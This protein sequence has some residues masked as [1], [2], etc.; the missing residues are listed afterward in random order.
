MVSIN[1]EVQSFRLRET[2]EIN[3]SYL[4][5][6]SMSDLLLW[7]WTA[8][9]SL[10]QV[11]TSSS[12][13]FSKATMSRY[14]G[15]WKR[16]TTWCKTKLCWCFSL[17]CSAKLYLVRKARLLP[18]PPQWNGKI[19]ILGNGLVRNCKIISDLGMTFDFS[20][21]RKPWSRWRS[22]VTDELYHRALRVHLQDAEGFQYVLVTQ[23]LRKSD[24]SFSDPTLSDLLSDW[25]TY[26]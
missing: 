12:R 4:N 17:L 18:S 21:F 11:F 22:L 23:W 25:V 13:N 2:S 1:D 24:E 10:L 19:N 26:G 20:V 15:I 14:L 8:S 3:Y 7:R 16:Q 9:R 5:S 6:A